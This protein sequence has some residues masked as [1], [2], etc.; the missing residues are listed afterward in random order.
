MYCQQCG[1]QIDDNAEFCPTCGALQTFAAAEGGTE[2]LGGQSYR[3]NEARAEASAPQ[4]Q[5]YQNP[6]GQASY[7]GQNPAYGAPQGQPYNGQ[8]YNPQSQAANP[9]QNPAYGAAQ[10]QPYNGQGPAYAQQPNY[11][12]TTA[13]PPQSVSFGEAIK[14][15]FQNYV[16]FEGR[17]TKSEYWFAFLFV[18]LVNLAVVWIPVIGQIAS[19]AFILP[20]LSI[21]VRRLHDTGKSWVYLLFGLIPLAGFIILIVFY[22]ADSDGDN[23]WGPAPQAW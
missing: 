16:N 2:V 12:N 17:A 15:Y 23:Q 20:S 22:C 10:G 19:L 11:A 7:S 6:A 14:L 1:A 21:A 5:A 9:G 13:R 3:P 18:F 4:G 8:A